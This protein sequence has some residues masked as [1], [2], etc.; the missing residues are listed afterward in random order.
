MSEEA[1]GTSTYELFYSVQS[2]G[3]AQR[4]RTGGYPWPEGHTSAFIG[5]GLY[6]WG[7]LE[8]AKL[9]LEMKQS[10]L[11]LND[12]SIIDIYTFEINQK[13]LLSLSKLDIRQLSEEN[14]NT[15]YSLYSR[16][17]GTTA[18]EHG[19]DYV[20]RTTGNFGEEHYFSFKVFHFFRMR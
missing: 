1:S 9:Y 12:P 11:N 13:D 7:N 15:W 8:S 6:T 14:A 5:L 3:D 19:Y 17:P 10:R 2:Q 18:L 20:V 4:L 16:S